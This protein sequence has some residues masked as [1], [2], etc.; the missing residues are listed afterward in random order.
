MDDSQP[1]PFPLAPVSAAI[2]AE[3]ETERRNHLRQLGYLKSGCAEIDDYVLQG[4][5]EKGHIVGLSAEE[6]TLGLT[7]SFHQLLVPF[8]VLTASSWVYKFSPKCYL[9]ILKRHS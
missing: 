5:F 6:E 3:Q 4:G 7:V 9:R 2:L 8:A 1:S